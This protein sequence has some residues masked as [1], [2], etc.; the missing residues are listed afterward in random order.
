MS[1]GQELF[2]NEKEDG[3]PMTTV[4]DDTWG[5]KMDAQLNMLVMPTGMCWRG[6]DAE[7]DRQIG[8]RVTNTF[9]RRGR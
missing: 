5:G 6:K 2:M 4:G 9:L 1:P 8:W 7:E 3:S